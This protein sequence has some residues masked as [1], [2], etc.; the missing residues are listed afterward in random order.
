[1]VD[2]VTE[3]IVAEPAGSLDGGDDSVLQTEGYG[4]RYLAPDEVCFSRTAGGVLRLELSD[5]CYRRVSIFR[6]RPLRDGERYLSL[7]DDRDE[8]GLLRELSELP[9]D[10]QS[11]VQAELGQRYFKPLL[12]GVK[13][14]QR[15]HDVYQW[16]VTTDRGEIQFATEHPR[17]SALLLGPNS[18]LIT[19]VDGN[20]YEI[21]DVTRLPQRD[22]GILL[23]LLG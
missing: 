16:E 23:E 18:W 4:L 13:K 22:R 15:K 2:Q 20:R 7:R 6:T 21:D 19:D 9:A 14:I 17:H 11:L 10:Q 8:I 3:D 1:M 12:R 5:R